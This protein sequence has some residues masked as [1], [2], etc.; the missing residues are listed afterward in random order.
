[1]Q[2]LVVSHTGDAHGFVDKVL[3]KHGHSRRVALTVPNF[4]FALAVIAETDLIAALP[5]PFVAMHAPRFGVV[6]IEAPLRL[7]AFRIRAIAP[8][9]A[10]MDAGVA[11][12]FDTLK[13]VVEA[14]GSFAHR[15]R[16][17]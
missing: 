15:K 5:R 4:M 9:V 3:A 10:M 13:E 2:H 11:W 12:L 16:R 14:G 8:K 17:R 6:S 1:M 7:P